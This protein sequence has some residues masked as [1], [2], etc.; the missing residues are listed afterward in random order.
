[1]RRHAGRI[2]V[3]VLLASLAQRA[4]AVAVIDIC[5]FLARGGDQA[6]CLPE[7]DVAPRSPDASD[8]DHGESAPLESAEA[9]IEALVAPAITLAAIAWAAQSDRDSTIDDRATAEAEDRRL[10]LML[11][12]AAETRPRDEPSAIPAELLLVA[13]TLLGCAAIRRRRMPPMGAARYRY[14]EL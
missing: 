2:V 1:M 4:D 10:P 11:G 8:R 6:V 13:L 9:E 3:A 5:S 12:A 14:R 7:F